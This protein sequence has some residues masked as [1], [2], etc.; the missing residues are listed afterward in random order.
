MQFSF[1][2]ERLDE[3]PSS[4]SFPNP[5]FLADFRNQEESKYDPLSGQPVIQVKKIEQANILH[6]GYL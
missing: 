6:L 1:G 5:V 4:F 2:F 3:N